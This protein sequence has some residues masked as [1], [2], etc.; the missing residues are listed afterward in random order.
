[1]VKCT[2]GVHIG[3]D[4]TDTGAEGGDL[5]APIVILAGASGLSAALGLYQ[6][7][8]QKK[9]NEYS[10]GYSSAY[11]ME[12]ERFW[13]DY[14]K[15]TGVR[16]RYPYRAGSIPNLTGQYGARLAADTAYFGNVRSA[17]NAAGF[18]YGIN[19]RTVRYSGGP[20]PMYG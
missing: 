8:Q 6:S 16:A 15:K 12:T 4:T 14:Y 9:I 2:E 10:Y 7:Y 3:A 18:L 17:A 13:N 1:M 19:A 11:N 20:G 5:V